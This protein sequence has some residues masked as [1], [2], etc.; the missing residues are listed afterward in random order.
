M[1]LLMYDQCWFGEDGKEDIGFSQKTFF[2]ANSVTNKCVNIGKT[3]E[4]ARLKIEELGK[5]DNFKC[6]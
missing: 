5:K 2:L 3:L 6:F 4:E 1:M